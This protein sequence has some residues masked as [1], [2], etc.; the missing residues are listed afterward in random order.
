M[1]E[2][3]T[4]RPPHVPLGL[5]CKHLNWRGHKKI[6]RVMDG[7]YTDHRY[8]TNYLLKPSDLLD[9]HKQVE[10]VIPISNYIKEHNKAI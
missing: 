6:Q 4:N 3:N 10:H 5:L 1:V 9:S 8:S 2:M 7:L